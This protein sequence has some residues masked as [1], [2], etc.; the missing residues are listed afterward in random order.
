MRIINCEQ[1]SEQWEVMRMTRPT[2]SNFGRI[3][4]PKKG[5]LSTSHRDYACELVAKQIGVFTEPPPSYWMEWGTEHEPQAVEVYCQRLG[6]EAEHVGFVLPD[7]TDDYGGSPD[8][9]VA[10]RKGLLE[11]KC[12]KP[13]TLIRYHWDGVLPETYIAQVQG[14]LLI[15]GC[16][17][18][19]FFAWHPELQPFYLRVEPDE[20]FHDAMRDALSEF[21]EALKELIAKVSKSGVNVIRWGQ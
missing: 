11:V 16:E 2:A 9:L 13:E 20:K 6:T 10:D 19:D 4:T 8:A 18:A 15:T 17:Y 3:I 1:G 7:D 12:P 14:L 21:R 5:Q